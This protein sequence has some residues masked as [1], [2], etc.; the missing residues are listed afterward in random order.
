MNK[1]YLILIVIGFI[2]SMNL[3]AQN[4]F[5]IGINA[6]INYPDVRGHEY[7]K[8]NNFKVGYLFG[9][10]FDYYQKENL[11]IKANINYEKKIKNCN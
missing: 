4:D 1:S 7:A 5:K 11:S 10:T 3:R 8:Y 2:F 6:G 9:V